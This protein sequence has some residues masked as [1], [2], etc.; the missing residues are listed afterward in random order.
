MA[1]KTIIFNLIFKTMWKISPSV[2]RTFSTKISQS[3]NVAHLVLA[4]PSEV[5]AVDW[6]FGFDTFLQ[7]VLSLFVSSVMLKVWLYWTM[8][9]CKRIYNF[10]YSMLIL[11][12]L[13]YILF[14]LCGLFMHFLELTY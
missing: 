1:R 12:Q 3:S 14:T 7:C 5:L 6:P 13:L 8:I 11:H 10:W 4:F 9:R 2:A